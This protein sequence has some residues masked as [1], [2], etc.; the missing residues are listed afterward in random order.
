MVDKYKSTKYIGHLFGCGRKRKIH[1]VTQ[2]KLKL[3]RRKSVFTVKVEIESEREISLCVDTIRK[4]ANEVGLFRLVVH[5]KPHVNKI[6]R[7]KRLKFA[8]EM[9]EKPVDF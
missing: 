9:F 4:L 8:K 5:K 2:C 1:R 7:G 3:D 6:N